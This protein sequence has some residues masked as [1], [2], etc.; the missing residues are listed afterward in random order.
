MTLIGTSVPIAAPFHRRLLPGV[1]LSRH[2][3]RRLTLLNPFHSKHMLT[4]YLLTW[5]FRSRCRCKR[6]C[7]TFC[8]FAQTLGTIRGRSVWC[9]LSP[10]AV[11][12]AS[13][14]PLLAHFLGLRPYV[15]LSDETVEL[16]HS[17]SRCT[18]RL[19]LCCVVTVCINAEP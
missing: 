13:F 8:A 17:V 9:W 6:A 18:P 11:V 3:S 7:R 4:C 14:A 16:A 1:V 5:C 12:P 10:A 15:R 2:V 19:Q